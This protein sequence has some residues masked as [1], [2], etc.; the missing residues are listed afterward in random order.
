M[1]TLASGCPGP[2][3]LNLSGTAISDIGVQAL[4]SGCPGLT[5]LCLCDCAKL[6]QEILRQQG[7]LQEPDDH[8][9]FS[10]GALS[11][12]RARFRVKPDVPRS[13]CRVAAHPA[14]AQ[15]YAPGLKSL[16]L[17]QDANVFH[18][19]PRLVLLCGLAV[20]RRSARTRAFCPTTLGGRQSWPLIPQAL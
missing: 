3:P 18:I 13:L 15:L 1:Q 12:V 10:T 9:S 8:C 20:P 7:Q 4:A 5:A 16:L 17:E 19:L 6:R 14:D 2:A 11:T